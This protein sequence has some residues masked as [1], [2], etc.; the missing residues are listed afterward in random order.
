MKKFWKNKHKKEMKNHCGSCGC[1][2]IYFL[3]VLGSAIFYIQHATSFWNGV[4]G[5]LKSFIWPVFLVHKL[6]G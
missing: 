1:G 3:G 4:L 2:G 6:L 5:V